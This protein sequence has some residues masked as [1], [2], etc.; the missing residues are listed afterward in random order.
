MLFLVILVLLFGTI[1]SLLNN[2]FLSVSNFLT[3]FR[4]GSVIGII[5]V[6]AM[7]IFLMGC[8]DLATG[9]AAAF[10]G[11]AV[12]L[13]MEKGINSFLAIIVVT[14]IIL[15]V[16]ALQGMIVSY[17]NCDSFIITFGAM[18]IYRGV[19][20]VLTRGVAI[21]DIDP[22]FNWIG[23]GYLFGVI[24]VPVVIML[25]CF[26]IGTF[27]LNYTRFGRRV[28]AVGGSEEAARLSGVNAKKHKVLGYV[29][30]GAMV[31]LSGL[32]LM[33][34]VNSGQPS[35]GADYNLDAISA[36]ALGGVS[37]GEGKIGGVLVG[38]F[39]ISMISNG[40]IIIGLNDYI[41]QIIKGIILIFALS[42]DKFLNIGELIRKKG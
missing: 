18:S 16:S 29:F 6:G 26:G 35:A 40:L 22:A 27:L 15:T 30:C 11:V 17:L 3:I 1:F 32:V 23:Q 12:G 13:M 42:S 9:A 10:F 24:G 8:F 41:Q 38:V 20:Y 5:S 14:L 39:L 33:Y 34:R 2:R 25:I 7:V 36:I 31:A 21:Y 37:K 19:C 4:Q 28:Y